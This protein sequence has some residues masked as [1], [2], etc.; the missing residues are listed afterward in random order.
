[1]IVEEWLSHLADLDWSRPAEASPGRQ[2][3]EPGPDSRW[4][5]SA[6]PTAFAAGTPSEISTWKES[7]GSGHREI[8]PF[9]PMT[10]SGG[11][12][13]AGGG[14]RDDLPTRGKPN[15]GTR[16]PDQGCR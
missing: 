5:P 11:T 13:S 15:S 10:D 12:G 7:R 14:L 6:A 3:L 1:M 9:L 2:R 8:K 4:P 16:R